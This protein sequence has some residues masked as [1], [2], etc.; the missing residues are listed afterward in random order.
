MVTLKLAQTADGYCAPAGGGRLQISGD[1]AMREVHLLRASHDAIMV[2]VGTV[3]SDDPQLNVRLQGLEGYSPVRVIL[4]S[5]LRLP[6]T[7]TLV[8]TA[9]QIPVWVIAAEDAPA[10]PE[11]VLRERGVEV[12]RVG[13]DATGALDL[14]AALHL[15]ALRG[16]TRIF[17]EG[18]PTVADALAKAVLADVVIVS[19]ADHSLAA[20]GVPALRPGLASALADRTRY[21]KLNEQRHGTDTFTTYERTA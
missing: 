16:I 12:M 18:G 2:G 14:A 8:R 11:L 20:Q 1:A 13:R 10:A 9:K 7:S 3:L 17:S 19:T 5:N 21:I 6:L 4:D 15:L